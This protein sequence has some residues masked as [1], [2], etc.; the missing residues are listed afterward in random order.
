[1]TDELIA[2]IER[3]KILGR[4]ILEECEQATSEWEADMATSSHDFDDKWEQIAKWKE[5]LA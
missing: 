1:M 3:L 4:K 2:E 5:E